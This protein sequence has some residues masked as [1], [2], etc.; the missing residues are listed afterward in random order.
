M[1]TYTRNSA[2]IGVLL[3]ADD[4]G[5]LVEGAAALGAVV[6]E[7]IAPRQSN[8]YAGSAGVAGGK[9]TYP[10]PRRVAYLVANVPYA[11]DVER[12]HGTLA[13][14]ADAIENSPL[15]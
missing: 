12:R 7:S 13:R 2:G 11:T 10:S 5:D 9:D 1:V 15:A 6:F 4:M 14:V 8:R 3:L